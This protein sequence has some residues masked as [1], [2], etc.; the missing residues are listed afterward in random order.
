[1]N[2]WIISGEVSGK[3]VERKTKNDKPVLSFRVDDGKVK[4]SVSVFE[5]E[6]DVH[7]GDYVVVQ[8]RA[9]YDS[10]TDKEGKTRYV[11]QCSASGSGLSVVDSAATAAPDSTEPDLAF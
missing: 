9:F 8:G 10:Y 5:P 1:M 4:H 3:P 11:T 6:V 2:V 7:E